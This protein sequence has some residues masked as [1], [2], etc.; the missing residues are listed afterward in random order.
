MKKLITICATIILGTVILAFGMTKITKEHRSV[1]VRGLAE[2][3]VDADMA[4]WKLSFSLGSNNLRDLQKFIIED[5]KV[6]IDFLEEHSLTS[7]DYTVLAPEINDA[8]VNLYSNPENRSY[9]YV[10]KQTVLIR[11]ENVQA[12]KKATEDTIELLGKGISVS[13][14]WDG[15][16]QYFFNGLNDVKPEMIAEATK[17]AR[18]AAEQFAHDSNSK[19][20]K[21]QTASQG[22]FSIE[23]AAPG[24]EYKKNVRVV[25]TVVYSL[26]D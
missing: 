5:T 11:S 14:D 16:V 26:A 19:V 25:T 15:K 10:A 9:D 18:A 21:I 24:L 6:V 2:R 13:S 17:N 3:E 12:V 8:T 4:V 7:K 22:L 20:G 1:S 23:D